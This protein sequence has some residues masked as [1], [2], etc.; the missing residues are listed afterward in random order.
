VW[1]KWIR[2]ILMASAA[3]VAGCAAAY[4]S[5]HMAEPR[6]AGLPARAVPHPRAE[7][8]DVAELNEAISL[9]YK[10]QYEQAAARLTGLTGRLE[11]SGDATRAAEALFWLGYCREKQ[12]RIDEAV[13]LYRRILQAYGDTP[14]A[15]Q[16]SQRLW[17]LRAR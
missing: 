11:A 7:A 9:I 1:A 16:A 5:Q 17:R 15:R 8:A 3:G 13:Q 12:G 2:A 4:K 6:W 10:L 14:A